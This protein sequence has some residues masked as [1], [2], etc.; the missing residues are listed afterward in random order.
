MLRL[1]KE[2]TGSR[3]G[4]EKIPDKSRASHNDRK[5]VSVQKTK[6][7]AKGTQELT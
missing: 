7:H 1:L 3:A 2:M 4:A 6:G 5:Q